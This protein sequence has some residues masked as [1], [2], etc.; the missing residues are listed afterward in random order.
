MGNT[1]V[2][3]CHLQN[4]TKFGNN[5]I[6]K[7]SSF[8][9]ILISTFYVS[10]ILGCEAQQCNVITSRILSGPVVRSDRLSAES[11]VRVPLF[12]F[13]FKLCSV[14]WNKH[15]HFDEGVKSKLLAHVLS[16]LLQPKFWAAKMS[17]NQ[18]KFTKCRINLRLRNSNV[19]CERNS[20]VPK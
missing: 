16:L 19:A 18:G 6:S 2:S 10:F 1:S 20:V 3:N 8:S 12:Q 15:V 17:R 5:F 13:A 11:V 14:S 9:H 4:L 7:L